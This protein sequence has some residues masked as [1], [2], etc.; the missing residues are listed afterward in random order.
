VAKFGSFAFHALLPGPLDALALMA[1]IAGSYAEAHD[2]I[3]DR[4]TRSG[5]AIGLSASLLGRAVQ[6]HLARRIVIDREVQTQILSAVGM[7]KKK[8]ATQV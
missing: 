3:R 1:Q 6:E 7:A 2:A 4:H 5:F 8:P